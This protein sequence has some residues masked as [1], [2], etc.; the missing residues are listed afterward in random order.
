MVRIIV[1]CS[2]GMSS[3]ALMQK[4]RSYITN[5]GVDAEVKAA[6]T[7]QIMS[8]EMDFD[9]V[10]L[11]P[12]IRFEKK[13]LQT[14]FPDKVIEVIPMQSYGRLDGE[15]VVKFGLRLLEEKKG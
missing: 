1:C 15:G 7:S 8:A 13:K 10:M 6:T 3:S 14:A 2:Q 5:A 11:G 12:Q 9:I 4:M